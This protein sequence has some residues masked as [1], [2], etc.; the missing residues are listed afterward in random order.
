MSDAGPPPDDPRVPMAA[1]RTLLAWIRTSLALMGFGFVVARLGLFLRE[2]AAQKNQ[3]APGSSGSSVW[4]G[5]ALI[6]AG[7][8]VSL[9]AAFQHLQRLK[10]FRAGAAMPPSG[11]RLAVGLAVAL[12][13]LGLLLAA[14]VASMG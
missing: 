13:I 6:G 7:I 5:A 12:G 8:V 3:P 4:I 1:E 10:A 9:A 14:Y 11:G 2:L